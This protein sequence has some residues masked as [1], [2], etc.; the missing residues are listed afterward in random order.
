MKNICL[1]GFQMVLVVLAL[2]AL[3]G[4]RQSVSVEADF[5]LGYD[6]VVKISEG[7]PLRAKVNNQ[8]EGF[9][10]ELQI[11][12]DKDGQ[13]KVIFAKAFEMAPS[14]EKEIEMYLPVY[15]IQ[16][17]F[18]VSIVADGREVYSENVVPKKFISPE[19]IVVAVVTD[20]PDDYRFV[21]SIS[22]PKYR[23]DDKFMQSYHYSSQ[24]TPYSVTVSTKSTVAVEVPEED[25]QK[26]HILYFESFA[27]FREKVNYDFMD[28]IYVGKT[29]H[30]NMTAETKDYLV[31]WMNEGNTLFIESGADY[32]RIMSQLPDELI[33]IDINGTEEVA[34]DTLNM[35]TFDDTLVRTQGVIRDVIDSEY[36]S[37]DGEAFGVLTRVGAGSLVTLLMDMTQSSLVEWDGTSNLL[38]AVFEA[39]REGRDNNIE[40]YE[41]YYHSWYRLSRIPDEMGPPYAL[42]V[43]IFMLYIVVVGPV[44]YYIFKRLDKRDHLWIAIPVASA[45]CLLLL[46]LVGF[47]TRYTK[48]ISNSISYIEYTE[49]EDYLKVD[50]D[51]ALFN[52]NNSDVTIAWSENENLEFSSENDRYYGQYRENKKLVGKMVTGKVREYT[53]YDSPLWTPSY[54]KASKVLPFGVEEGSALAKMQVG[55]EDMALEITNPTPLDLEYAFA[56]FG[57]TMFVIGDLEAGETVVVDDTYRGDM[58]QFFDQKLVPNLYND[59]TTEGRKRQADIEVLRERAERHFNYNMSAFEMTSSSEVTVYGM[60]RDAVGYDIDINGEDTKDFSRNVVTLSGDISYNPGETVTLPYGSL[61][62]RYEYDEFSR[63]HMH[64]YNDYNIGNI[65][66][67]YDVNEGMFYWDVPEFLDVDDMTVAIERIYPEEQFYD[68]YHRGNGAYHGSSIEAYFYL[69]NRLTDGWDEVT[70]VEGEMVTEIDLESDKYVADGKV[71]LK[72]EIEGKVVNGANMKAPEL[73]VKGVVTE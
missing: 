44:L 43:V 18:K 19:H 50:T 27:Q 20:Q 28:Y 67:I 34:M 1:K 49:G 9:E 38:V 37:L 2:L 58:W 66:N 4:C 59:R 25:I 40:Y 30:L 35:M 31:E 52:N 41:D 12:I 60:N 53:V 13:S 47:A 36:I 8:G 70:L 17:N 24:P 54:M 46:Y 22:L 10:G 26:T 62:T 6:G 15:M 7:N 63:G 65:A 71:Q 61:A 56:V 5:A 73:S 64:V 23:I 68:I 11:E 32:K 51:I 57:N 69:Y 45:V 29:S 55:E 48:P 21:N 72:F 42:M 14:S 33:N 3:S 16:K 39:S